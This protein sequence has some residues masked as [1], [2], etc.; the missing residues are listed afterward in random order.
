MNT[1]EIFHRWKER[2]AA[3]EFDAAFASRVM[4]RLPRPAPT[5]KSPWLAAAVVILCL[6]SAAIHMTF[7][8]FLTLAGLNTG[9]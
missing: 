2:S 8:L 9:N 1:D 4:G 3:V 6:G 5:R 7:V